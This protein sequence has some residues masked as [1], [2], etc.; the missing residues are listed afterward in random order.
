MPLE[1]YV[2]QAPGEFAIYCLNVTTKKLKW[3]NISYHKR[4]FVSCVLLQHKRCSRARAPENKS[5]ASE[6][7][8]WTKCLEEA[9][10]LEGPKE[11]RGTL[12]RNRCNTT[13]QFLYSLKYDNLE[14]EWH[15]L[16]PC[17]C[18]G[19][20]PHTGRERETASLGGLTF[21]RSQQEAAGDV[22]QQSHDP[23]VPRPRPEAFHEAVLSDV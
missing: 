6:Q 8:I 13:L 2:Q 9:R 3:S 21:E 7:S 15:Q 22:P 17:Y 5:C 10:Y 16:C 18:A 20:G 11:V 12:E 23:A 14:H 4:V 19:D 1:W